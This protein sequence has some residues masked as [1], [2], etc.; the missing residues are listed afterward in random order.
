MHLPK[1]S[2]ITPSFNQGKYL[3]KTLASVREQDYQDV[4]HFVVDGG[5][6]DDT[7][8]ILQRTEG[9]TGWVSE[10]DQGQ[11]H[12]INKGLSQATGEVLTWLN[13]D[14]QLTPGALETVG[15]LF[16]KKT[17]LDLVYGNCLMLYETGA[18][19]LSKPQSN[20]RKLLGGMSF[21]QPA[22]FFSRRI[23]EKYG[24]YLRQD[25]HYGMDYDFFLF[26]ALEGK[27][28]YL[29][30]TLAKY[31]FHPTSKST[32]FQVR[33]ARDYARTLQ[34][35]LLSVEAGKSW[36]PKLTLAGLL[37]KEETKDRYPFSKRIHTDEIKYAVLE[38]LVSQI[39]F[40]YAGL[41]LSEARKRL[42]WLRQE[43]PDFFFSNP[44]LPET[45]RRTRLLPAGLIR[46]YRG[47]KG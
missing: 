39:K 31:L 10:S 19:K 16:A 7:I 22:S 25:L 46:A 6:T 38:N 40:Y 43:A 36:I 13:S 44:Q 28:D 18:E 34:K 9:L 21:A 24:G 47:W 42:E 41:E 20:T 4:E 8:P 29:D 3:P 2:I 26:V 12:A 30:Q 5:S 23:L 27:V 11:S 32:Q 37:P 45:L 17:E 33:F 1:I 15:R 35:L 14:D